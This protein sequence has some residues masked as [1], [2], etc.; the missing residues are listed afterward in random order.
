M[1]RGFGWKFEIASESYDSKVDGHAT[2]PLEESNRAA[3]LQEG[4]TIAE[5]VR[6]RS[7]LPIARPQRGLSTLLRKAPGCASIKMSTMLSNI[8]RHTEQS[9]SKLRMTQAYAGHFAVWKSDKV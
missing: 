5:V 8:V 2:R 9:L 6:D 7:L 1:K 3:G 4:A